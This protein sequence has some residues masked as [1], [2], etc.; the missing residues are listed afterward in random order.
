VG[1]KT[2][3][4]KI[5]KEQN[6][7]AVEE[8][9]LQQHGHTLGVRVEQ[10]PVAHLEI[11][12]EGVEYDWGAGKIYYRGRPLKEKHTIEGFM[13]LIKFSLSEAVLSKK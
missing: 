3:L 9:L 2:S 5:L 12:G 13:T 4:T 7:F 6:D 10:L 11:V 8:T 1:I